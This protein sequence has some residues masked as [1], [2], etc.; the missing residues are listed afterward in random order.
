MAACSP[1]LDWR[2]LPSSETGVTVLFPCR[3]ERLVRDVPLDHVALPMRLWSC[4][5]SGATFSLALVDVATAARV[6]PTLS[7][8]R[9]HASANLGLAPVALPYVVPGATPNDG[10]E[11]FAIATRPT[12]GPRI[13]GRTA[14]FVHGLRLY[15]ATVL[16]AAPDTEAMEAFFGSIRVATPRP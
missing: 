9:V 2:Q 7:S 5:A 13:V 15:E 16:G 8:W 1:A 3:P 11:A 10:S 14:F 6:G 4:T 12:G